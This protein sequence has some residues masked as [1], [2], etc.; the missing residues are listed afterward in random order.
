MARIRMLTSVSGAG[1]A[2]ASG[3][4]IDLPGAEASQWADGVRAEMVRDEA[5]E[6]PEATTARPERATR[7]QP[8]R[9]TRTE[10][11]TK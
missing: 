1:F 3:E 8:A 11:R 5:P 2:W 10:T 6:T 9:R 7:K 4:V